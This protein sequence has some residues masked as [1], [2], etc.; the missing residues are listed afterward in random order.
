GI[1]QH[2][3]DGERGK[4]P[5]DFSTG[6]GTTSSDAGKALGA[7]MNAFRPDKPYSVGP[8]KVDPASVT[9]AQLTMVR[10]TG[11]LFADKV[12]Y[13]KVV[14]Y[15]G[16]TAEITPLVLNGDVDYATHGFPL[17]TDKAFQDKGYRIIRGPILTGP[18]P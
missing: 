15:Q 6:G 2:K 8:Y 10:N 3:S 12:N 13:D 11:G 1:K 16:E 14:V 17:A 4:K 7:E 5:Q 9:A 18:A